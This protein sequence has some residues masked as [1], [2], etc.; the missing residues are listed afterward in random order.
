MSEKT[1]VTDQAGEENS[2]ESVGVKQESETT[3]RNFLQLAMAAGSGLAMASM[4]PGIARE[5]SVTEAQA[6]VPA[7]PGQ[8]LQSI[9]EIKSA[10]TGPTKILKAVLKVLDENKAYLGSPLGTN[11]PPSCNTGQMRYF[12]GYDASVSPYMRKVW[13][14]VHGIPGPGPT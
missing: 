11:Q 4:L 5:L 14:A 2:N 9:M 12:S 1:I 10:G 3:R 8:P 6:C 7:A 13:P